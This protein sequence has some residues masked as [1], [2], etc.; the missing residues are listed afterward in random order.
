MKK[1]LPVF[2]IL[3]M[4]TSSDTATVP[5]TTTTTVPV[6]TTTTVPVT[7]TT[8]HQYF[9]N[10]ETL[11]P[12][13]QSLKIIDINSD[14]PKVEF[15][16]KQGFKL[17]EDSLSQ[18]NLIIVVEFNIC[19]TPYSNTIS[20][21]LKNYEKCSGPYQSYLTTWSTNVR[22]KYGSYYSYFKAEQLDLYTVKYTLGLFKDELIISG[23]LDNLN[24]EKIFYQFN[25]MFIW[26][27]KNYGNENCDIRLTIDGKDLEYKIEKKSSKV[28][29]EQI[30]NEGREIYNLN[31]LEANN[32][33]L[34]WNSTY[35]NGLPSFS[36][37]DFTQLTTTTTTTT[38]TT[39]PNA[40]RNSCCLT[41]SIGHNIDVTRSGDSVL[42]QINGFPFN[43]SRLSTSLSSEESYS[44]E[45]TLLGVDGDI[46]V[47]ENFEIYKSIG[48]F[49]DTY[50][51]SIGSSYISA[52][53]D[54]SSIVGDGRQ[55][56][57][58][59]QILGNSY[60]GSTPTEG[61]IILLID[62]F[63]NSR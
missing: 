46:Y 54:S 36:L 51:G 47:T 40:G 29:C 17:T 5:V 60:S 8:T 31:L 39:L 7:T 35:F 9:Q 38:T 48:N 14:I 21:S 50:S 52:N 11:L 59:I 34:F 28:E 45:I 15:I 24:E 2:L 13:I 53:A 20:N 61:L 63:Y 10:P 57:I 41:L 58:N 43:M 18:N 27:I 16:L 26:D 30:N 1:Y 44:G 62:Y 37:S 55:N 49:G 19:D 3:V 22:S 6:T 4:C 12:L 32:F 56:P 33:N 23:N 25:S 42:G